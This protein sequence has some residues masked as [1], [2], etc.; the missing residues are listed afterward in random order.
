[1]SVKRVLQH[2]GLGRADL[3]LINTGQSRLHPTNFCLSF[4]GGHEIFWRIMQSIDTK[5]SKAANMVASFL[6]HE[7]LSDQVYAWWN[8]AEYGPYVPYCYNLIELSLRERE[9]RIVRNMYVSPMEWVNEFFART[10]ARELYSERELRI[11]WAATVKPGFLPQESPSLSE[12]SYLL[13]AQ[14]TAREWFV[15]DEPS[16]AILFE[17]ALESFDSAYVFD[18]GRE[19]VNSI[20]S[21]CRYF[22]AQIRNR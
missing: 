12:G 21:E 2:E 11:L 1:E 20:A 16:W 4:P 9:L 3:L 18:E 17:S 15:E 19:I 6:V 7:C 13:P 8:L 10:V 5:S 22:F 14:V